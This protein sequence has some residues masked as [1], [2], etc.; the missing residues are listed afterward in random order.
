MLALVGASIPTTGGETWQLIE[1][2]WDKDD[3]APTARSAVQH[4]AKLNGA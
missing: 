2:K 3:R 4:R 1:D